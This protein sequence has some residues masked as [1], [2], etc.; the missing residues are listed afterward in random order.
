MV[1]VVDFLEMSMQL[2]GRDA[3]K[4]DVFGDWNYR[5]KKTRDEATSSLAVK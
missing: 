4:Y 3:N 5:Q 2:W 1:K